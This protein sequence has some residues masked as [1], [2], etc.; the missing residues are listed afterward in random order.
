MTRRT[1]KIFL[2]LLLLFAGPV[3]W[4]ANAQQVLELRKAIEL[5]GLVGLKDSA[6][7][8]LSVA[9][10]DLHFAYAKRNS[11]RSAASIEDVATGSDCR[12]SEDGEQT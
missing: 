5:T 11:D 3:L 7:R 10:G 8:T 2:A 6:K 9:K 12:R 1:T 4:V